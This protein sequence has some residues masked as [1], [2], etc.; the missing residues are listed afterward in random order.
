MRQEN[1][2]LLLALLFF[3]WMGFVIAI[4]YVT[5]RPLLWSVA[6]GLGD[7]LWTLIVTLMLVTNGSW[8]GYLLLN[9]TRPPTLSPLE[10]ALLSIGFGLGILGIFSLGFAALGW[11]KPVILNCVQIGLFLFFWTSKAWQPVVADLKWAVQYWRDQWGDTS[12]W[13][14]LA[15][16]VALVLTLILALAPPADGFDALFYH[17]PGPQQILRDG[18]IQVHNIPHF[19]FP[20]L[21]EGVFLWAMGLG[22]DRAAQLLH[23]VWALLSILLLWHWVQTIWDQKIAR[24][25]LLILLTIPSLFVLASWAYTDYALVFYGLAALY[26]VYKAYVN[27]SDFKRGWLILAGVAAGMAMG[28]KYTS[29][30]VPVSVVVLIV[31]WQRRQLKSALGNVA[32]FSLIALAVAAPWYIRNA[33]LMG[34][35]VYPFVWDGKFW[36]DFRSAWYAAPH[37]GIGWNFVELLLLPINTTLGHRDANYYDGRMGPLFLLLFPFALYAALSRHSHS[38]PQDRTILAI[39]LFGILNVAFWTFGVINSSAL[40]QSRLL[41]PALIPFA[42]I[43]S[44]GFSKIREL[45]TSQLQIS[46]ISNIILGLVVFV[47]LADTAITVLL[48]NPMRYAAG[49]ETRVEYLE[50]V[51]PNYAAAMQLLNETPTD[52]FVYFL[53]EPRSYYATRQVQPDP[54]LDNLAHDID[55]YGSPEEIIAAWKNQGYTHVLLYRLGADFLIVK[56]PQKM[57]E[58]Q[59]DILATLI[60]IY[61]E[62]V[63]NTDNQSYELYAIP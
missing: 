27:E 56:D 16:W 50:K 26:G 46:F 14:K 29:F 9:R 59:Q 1:R 18:G 38:K 7:T 36:D 8:L 28:V 20:A 60:Q 31:W 34:N 40:W 49:L 48:K 54:I 22:S 61:L 63:G 39:C 3:L 52:A 5:Q 13:V 25:T 53:L 62:P 4:F 19:W 33:I 6:L 17:L 47:A 51:Q 11:A 30:L 32:L 21:P 43:C 42:A 2:R 58:Q 24:N 55:Q 37:S 45:D 10:R 44:L 57:T 41:F 35:P 15:L 23:L 12:R